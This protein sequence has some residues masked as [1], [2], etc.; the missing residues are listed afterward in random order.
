MNRYT[1]LCVHAKLLQLCLTLCDPMTVACQAPL[2]IGFSRQQ[3][4]SGLSCPPPGNLP[5]PGIE[6]LSFMSP[7]LG[8]VLCHQ[9]HLGRPHTT[10]YEICKQPGPTVEHREL[11][12][13]S[14]NNIMEKNLKKD[15]FFVHL[16]IM[17][18]CKSTIR[19][20]QIS[21]S[22]MSDSL[23]PH[24]SQHARPPCSS[25]TPRVH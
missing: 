19:S 9:S 5:D 3:Y 12:S 22:V 8:Q 10:I 24:E 23:R 4:W 2:S 25:P 15:H 7:A 1:L 21:R 6:L 20:D 18:Y 13:V 17:Q 11:Y 16:K 14:Y